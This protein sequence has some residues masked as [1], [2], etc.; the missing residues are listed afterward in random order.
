[1]ADVYGYFATQACCWRILDI[2][3]V[4]NLFCLLFGVSVE[5]SVRFRCFSDVNKAKFYKVFNTIFCVLVRFSRYFA[6]SEYEFGFKNSLAVVTP[7]IV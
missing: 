1:M 7:Y 2:L 6:T 4:P 3:F 5:S